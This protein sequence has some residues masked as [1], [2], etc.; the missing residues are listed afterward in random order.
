MGVVSS[1][2]AVC[3]V[4][5]VF[6]MQDAVLVKIHTQPLLVSAKNSQ[7]LS[8]LD[9]SVVKGTGNTVAGSNIE[10]FKQTQHI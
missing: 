3:L 4:L 10:K 6:V 5:D 2:A 9:I 7:Q 1:P 8:R